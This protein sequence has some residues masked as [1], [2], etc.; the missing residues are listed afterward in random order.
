VSLFLTEKFAKFTAK[1][2]N[3][4]KTQNV[5]ISQTE[6]EKAEKFEIVALLF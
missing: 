5:A 2:F 4:H 1:S 6:T 3:N